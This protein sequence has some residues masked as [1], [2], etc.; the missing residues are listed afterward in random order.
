M[1]APVPL[2][3]SRLVKHYR[4]RDGGALEAVR[5][6]SF[7]VRAGECFGL[8]GPNGAGKSTTINCITGFFPPTSGE[9]LIAGVD[10]HREPKQARAVLGVCA[11][12]ETLD[13]DF[14]VLDQLV[15]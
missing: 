12:E 2:R 9:I 3:V 10:V 4:T 14:R 5:G 8:L 15:R 6:V 7:D 1:S 13:S 11:Q